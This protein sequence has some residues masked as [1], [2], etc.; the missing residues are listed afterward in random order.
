MESMA[1]GIVARR[2][3]LPREPVGHRGVAKGL[4]AI[5]PVVRP[6]GPH[7]AACGQVDMEPTVPQQA[8]DRPKYIT[9]ILC[10]P[11]TLGRRSQHPTG[12]RP[13]PGDD[14]TKRP[15]AVR[16]ESSCEVGLEGGGG[17]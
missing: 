1:G 11:L 16:L 8:P 17:V 2:A 4:Q 7:L 15:T 12:A 13:G 9:Y 6:H 5:A 3:H 10:Y 14:C